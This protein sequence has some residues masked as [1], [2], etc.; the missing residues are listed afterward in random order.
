MHVITCK[1]IAPQ[2]SPTLI[3]ESEKAGSIG[4]HDFDSMFRGISIISF[5]CFSVLKL[6]NITD[7]LQTRMHETLYCCLSKRADPRVP[8]QINP[9]R[10]FCNPKKW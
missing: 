8:K 10:G 5:I 9:G 4:Q 6:G 1:A 7:L 2:A 3:F